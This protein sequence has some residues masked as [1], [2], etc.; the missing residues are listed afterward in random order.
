MRWLGL[1]AVLGCSGESTPMQVDAG[2]KPHPCPSMP[3]GNCSAYRTT[4]S[5]ID[6]TARVV[7]TYHGPPVS[8]CSM[9]RRPPVVIE[10]QCTNGCVIET[11][12]STGYIGDSASQV[13]F[14][15]QMLCA[16]TP[17]AQV[18]APCTSTNAACYPTSAELNPDG[19]VA[20]NPFLACVMGVCTVTP[21]P[22][23]AQYLA[24]CPSATLA[25][26]GM[27]NVNGVVG[28]LTQ[29]A[30]PYPCLLAWDSTTNTVASGITNLCA[31]DWD[32]SA[33][34]LCDGSLTVIA[35]PYT[36][37]GVCKPGPRGT[38][39]PAMLTPAML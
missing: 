2:K 25:A 21:N 6:S 39:T 10:A 28:G 20:S 30:H 24:A 35:G 9:C 31:G 19:T 4:M 23:I 5:C 34:A 11:A 16:E 15:P 33:E 26:F 32:C 22:P 8:T 1:V 29:P 18:G 7:T 27:P 38:L 17:R 12:M 36:K 13:R 14:T 3:E 37:L